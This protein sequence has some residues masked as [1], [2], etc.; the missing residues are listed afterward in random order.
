MSD[1]VLT[2]NAGSSSIKFSLF[3]AGGKE[4]AMRAVGEVEG[5]GGGSFARIRVKSA[6]GEKLL[7]RALEP[8]EAK[9]HKAALVVILAFINQTFPEARVA[10]VGH[11][12]VHGG[13]DHDKA[14][15]ID[16]KALAGLAALEPLAPLHQPHNLAGIY[17][18][19][20]AFPDAPQVACFDTAF[21]RGHTFENDAYGLPSAL[22]DEGVRRYGFHGISFDYVARR[23]AAIAPQAAAGRVV[24]AHLGNGASLCAIRAGK[25]VATTM[26]FS[27]L[28]GVSMGT[29]PGQLDPGVLLYLIERRGY[30]AKRLTDLLYKQSGFKGMSGISNDM[31]DLEASSDPRAARAISY[32]THRVR[33]EI[34]GL[35]STLGGLDALV[36]TA[37]IGEHSLRVRSEVMNGLSF[38]G[39]IG[40][41]ARNG[42]NATCISADNPRAGIYRP[43]QRRAKD[44]RTSARVFARRL[45]AR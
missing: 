44:R 36:F 26:G 13:P 7:E 2:L 25:S 30:D 17:A 28:D 1:H 10:A 34:A 37:G 38:L 45:S 40:D 24:V 41:E 15:L 19:R 12:V 18:A 14:A 5:L 42:Q 29:R 39:I 33:Y 21:H 6:A 4:L 16:D 20:A 31:R 27:T 43:D 3:D 32:F 23:F 11:R 8:A 9:S 22:Y 35:A